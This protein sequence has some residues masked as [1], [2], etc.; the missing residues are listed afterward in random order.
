M[1]NHKRKI[2]FV[3]QLNLILSVLFMLAIYPFPTLSQ[4]YSTQPFGFL[5]Q[6][7]GCHKGETVKGLHEAKQYL[8]KFGYLNAEIRHEDVDYF[9]DALEAAIK[10][11]QLNYN[12]ETSGYLDTSTVKQMMMPRYHHRE[13][14]K[15]N[16]SLHIVSHYNFFR[17]NPKWLP[18]KME[19][20]YRFRSS[21]AANVDLPT[22]ESACARALSSWA[23]VSN[24]RFRVPASTQERND[25]VM[26]FHRGDHGDGFKFDGPLGTLA[27][28]FAPQNGRLHMD[29]DENWSTNPDESM[30]DLET[31]CLH[32]LGHILG[33][34]HSFDTTADM[35]SGIDLGQQ[36]R[37]PTT[38][39]IDGLRALYS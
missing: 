13:N 36:K 31:V 26:G 24:F 16:G 17:G 27:H 11:Y 9:D 25:I 7:E 15:N 14:A 34:H 2:P 20:I 18:E 38:D 29:A 23:A 3:L 4:K 19:L 8:K 33:L 39:D 30:F 35:Y 12:L 21:A 37:T 1:A 6:L 32:E 10:S 28:A 5:K 22:L